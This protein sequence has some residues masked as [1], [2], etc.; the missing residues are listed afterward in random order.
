MISK[1]SG[2]GKGVGESVSKRGA[3]CIVPLQDDRGEDD[4]EAGF[5]VVG[6]RCGVPNDDEEQQRELHGQEQRHFRRRSQAALRRSPGRQ[7][8][9]T[10]E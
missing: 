4:S 8:D 3:P 6:G 5:D 7:S 9:A 1:F 10:N 2:G